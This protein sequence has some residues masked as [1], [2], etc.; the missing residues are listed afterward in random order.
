MSSTTFWIAY[1]AFSC[2]NAA[3]VA[4]NLR[5]SSWRRRVMKETPQ[6][7]AIAWNEGYQR[8]MR[9]EL[10]DVQHGADNPYIDGPAMREWRTS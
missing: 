6:R 1:A 2:L 4:Y 8:G 5:T 10:L 9:D 3:F 7:L